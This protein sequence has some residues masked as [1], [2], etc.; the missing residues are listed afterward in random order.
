MLDFSFENYVGLVQD[1]LNASGVGFSKVG[2]EVR[3][4]YSLDQEVEPCEHDLV[5]NLVVQNRSFVM[6]LM[7]FRVLK[8]KDSKILRLIDLGVRPAIA[9][10]VAN[11]LEQKISRNVK[12]KNMVKT[13]LDSDFGQRADLIK[14]TSISQMLSN[15][16]V[17]NVDQRSELGSLINDSEVMGV[18]KRLY[19][20]ASFSAVNPGYAGHCQFLNGCLLNEGMG[21]SFI[22]REKELLYEYYDL[23]GCY[24]TVVDRY[25][26]STFSFKDSVFQFCVNGGV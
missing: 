20:L 25:Y 17:N 6:A 3:A 1:S 26:L 10:K 23:P 5:C 15:L 9:K 14:V 7:D 11:W 12:T 8:T 19:G 13:L 22:E 24:Q 2:D 4:L 16:G 21:K 18:F